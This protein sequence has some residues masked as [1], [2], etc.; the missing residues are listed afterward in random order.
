MTHIHQIRTTHALALCATATLMSACASNPTDSSLPSI[1]AG[2]SVHLIG[3]K[4]EIDTP[5][6]KTTGQNV[7]TGAAG[8]AAGGALMGAGYGFMMG[9]ACGPLFVV[10]SPAGLVGGAAGG[11]IFGA[12]VGGISNGMLALPKE[13][14][15]ALEIVMTAA[16]ADFSGPQTLVEEFKAQSE[17]RWS[18]ADAGAPIEIA[19]GVEGLYIDQG[20]D[21][22][23]TVKVVNSMIVSYGAGELDRTRRILFTYVSE[24]HHVDYW[25]EHD[26][27]NF[28]AVVHEGFGSNIAD[29]I[30]K[31]A[32][33]SESPQ[34]I[35]ESVVNER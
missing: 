28:Q 18:V 9:F 20:K 16:I 3:A 33:D 29:M 17:D 7:A 35:D 5:D 23:L 10:C 26:G 13:K 1:P 31:L 30:G 32:E 15:E 8:G 27:A 25:I 34:F 21:D 24:R 22:A 19:L 11:A 6:A 12:A 4:A 2:S 14:A